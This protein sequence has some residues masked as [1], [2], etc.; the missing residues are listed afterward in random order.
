MLKLNPDKFIYMNELLIIERTK[1]LP[2]GGG[3]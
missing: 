3:E 2:G 1:M